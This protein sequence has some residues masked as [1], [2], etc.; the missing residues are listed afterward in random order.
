MEP[1]KSLQNG[2]MVGIIWGEEDT[3]QLPRGEDA[4]GPCQSCLTYNLKCLCCHHVNYAPQFR[5][6]YFIHIF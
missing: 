3:V 5:Q 4:E 6:V 1:K 2:V